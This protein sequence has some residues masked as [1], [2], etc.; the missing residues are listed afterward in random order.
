LPEEIV[1][2]KTGFKIK[3]PMASCTIAAGANEVLLS[4]NSVVQSMGLDVE[5]TPV[6]C[7]GLDF[8][9][10]WIEL[11][12]KGYPSTIYAKVAPEAVEQIIRE[13]LD[14]DF[15]SAYA[16]RSG[17][18]DGETVP[19]LD[20]LDVW[21]NQ[22]RWIS[23][24]CGTINPESIDE[25]IAV[26][27]Y[28]GLKKCLKM[29]PEETI[30]ELKKA[31]L[32][33]RGGAGFPTWIKWNICKEQPGNVKYVIAN[34]DEGDP[35]AFMNRL[36]AE[37]DPHRIL[38]GLIIAGHTIGANRGFVFVRAE[39]PLAAKRLMKAAEDA[40]AKGFL[41]GNILGSGYC[42]DIEVFLS[43]GAFV[44]GEETA[45]IAAIQGE[46][47]N[48]IQ[49]PPFPAV[50]GL[51]GM[52]TIINNVESL[53]HVATIMAE[54]WQK[55]AALGTEKS[56]GTKMYCV[57]G[58]VQRTGAYEVPIGTPIK[59]LLYDIAGGPPEGKVIK[60][61][62]LGGP[63]GGC[64]PADRFDLPMDYDSLQSAGAIMGSGGM[65]VLDNTNCMVDMARFFLSFTT[66][67]SCGKC[68]VGRIG[69]RLMYETLKRI[70]NGEGTEGDIELLKETSDVMQKACL[71]ALGR[72]ASNP[73][74]TTLRYF[75]NEYAAHIEAKKCEA[76]VCKALLTYCIDPEKCKGCHV[77]VKSCPVEALS[78]EKGSAPV[79]DQSKCIKCG[80]CLDSCPFGAIEKKPGRIC[81]K[82]MKVEEGC[83]Q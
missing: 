13:Y 77:C 75:E 49:R 44:C 71:C 15:S 27:G 79:I 6:G 38:E 34:C 36:L 72:T 69:T 58:A 2:G 41:G 21:N 53:A 50:K 63:S 19:S 83:C 8:I 37:S 43:A 18:P 61:V 23:G 57:T 20:E 56:K 59:K 5:V 9:D 52:P 7:M 42:F 55:F 62:Q 4:I 68:S 82:T 24:K 25:Y 76:L 35:G 17:K 40:R 47:A 78:G 11:S 60:A 70:T 39:K 48:P 30:E 29:A 51:W 33:G 67:E 3:V 64:V 22:V 32:R 10:P 14:R 1:H 46:R 73:I 31:N 65:V 12:K 28:E 81:E 54:G 66:A 16:F 80:T 74:L 45:M 26:G